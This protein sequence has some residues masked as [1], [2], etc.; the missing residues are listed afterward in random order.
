MKERKKTRS[1]YSEAFRVHIIAIVCKTKWLNFGAKWFFLLHA[2]FPAVFLS[3]L[4][5][6]SFGAR[7]THDLSFLHRDDKKNV[8]L[9]KSENMWYHLPLI[10]PLDCVCPPLVCTFVCSAVCPSN[11]E[12]TLLHI[13][14]ILEV[15]IYNP[16]L[17][18]TRVHKKNNLII[19]S[20]V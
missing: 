9:L 14:N 19:F 5:F 8:F 20:D 2:L 17:N 6:I 18:R 11:L 10:E 12:V 13:S 3:W 16:Q 1:V 15:Y 7:Y 4:F